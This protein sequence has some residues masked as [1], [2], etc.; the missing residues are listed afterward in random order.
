MKKDARVFLQHI[1]ESIEK[2]EEYTRGMREAGFLRNS[3]V[4]DAT[5][6]RLEVIG[7]AAKQIPA[8]FRQKHPNVPW[9]EMAGLRDKLIHHYFGVSLRLTFGVV[10]NDL[11]KLRK[12]ILAVLE[13]NR[14]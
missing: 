10:T 2:I 11:P 3:S 14:Q 9:V 5:I 8:E 7:E 13:S 12:A 6:R 4:Q 1:L